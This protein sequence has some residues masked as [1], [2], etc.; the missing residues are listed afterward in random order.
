[1]PCG[2]AGLSVLACGSLRSF[3]ACVSS[4][5]CSTFSWVMMPSLASF[6][7]CRPRP[8]FRSRLYW[9][10]LLCVAP[11]LLVLCPADSSLLGVLELWTVSLELSKSFVLELLGSPFPCSGLEVRSPVSIWGVGL[12]CFS[13]AVRDHCPALL[14]VSVWIPVFNILSCLVIFWGRV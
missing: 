4:R 6:L 3:Q 7:L 12:T 8:V 14:V 10:H 9:T 2:S 1:M 13:P 5:R 11:S